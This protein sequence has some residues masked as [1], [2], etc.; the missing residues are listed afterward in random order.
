MTGEVD[1]AIFSDEFMFKDESVATAGIKAY[2]TGVRKLFDQVTRNR[3][4]GSQA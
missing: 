1:A 4:P 3:R 2:A